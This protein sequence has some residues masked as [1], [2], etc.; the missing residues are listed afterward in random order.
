MNEP[1]PKVQTRMYKFI[2]NFVPV[3][4]GLFFLTLIVFAIFAALIIM[5][6]IFHFYPLK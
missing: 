1:N 5:I 4:I 2:Q 6:F 3:V